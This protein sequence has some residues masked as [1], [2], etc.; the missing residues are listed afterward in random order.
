MALTD[1][2][3]AIINTGKFYTATTG[4]AAPTNYLAPGVAWTDLGHTSIENILALQ[5]EGGEVTVLGT[6]QSEVFRSTTTPRVDSFAIISNQWD[7]D[8]YKMYFGANATQDST[9]KLVSVPSA[10][11]AT[12]KAFLAV[13]TAGAY[14]F[15][16]HAAKV[17]I[18]R[19]DDLDISERNS[20]AGIPL[21]VTPVSHSGST[22]YWGI[23]PLL[24]TGTAP[25]GA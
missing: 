25:F 11:T 15:A 24:P 10:P 3:V 1:A 7:V 4:T 6:L 9:S 13:F 5:S 17:E 16:V 20:I 18:K 2:A 22:S 19:G 14:N 8:T 12:E 23:T 21:L